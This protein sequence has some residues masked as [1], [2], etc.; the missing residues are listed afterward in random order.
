ML[1]LPTEYINFHAI[2]QT[3]DSNNLITK[4][5]FQISD[6]LHRSHLKIPKYLDLAT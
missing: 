5:I 3:Y 4:P 2:I 6:T 1:N